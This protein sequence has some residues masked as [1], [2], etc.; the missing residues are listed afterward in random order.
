MPDFLRPRA[1]EAGRGRR[2]AYPHDPQPAL[3]LLRRRD[4]R[5]HPYM[6]SASEGEGE[7][8]KSGRGKR[9]GEDFVV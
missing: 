1:P 5:E 6:M 3:G 2:Q 7:S 8:W 9:G 4:E